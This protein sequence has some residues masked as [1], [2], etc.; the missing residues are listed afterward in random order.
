MFQLFFQ[1]QHPETSAYTITVIP[2]K[3]PKCSERVWEVMPETCMGN[4][5]RV[6]PYLY[7]CYGLWD[8]VSWRLVEENIY[9]KQDVF[10]L[11]KPWLHH[12]CLENVSS[13]ISN[14]RLVSRFQ[15]A[16]MFKATHSNFQWIRLKSRL[17]A[18][19]PAVSNCTYIVSCSCCWWWCC[20]GGINTLVFFILVRGGAPWFYH[21]GFLVRMSHL[22]YLWYLWLIWLVVWNIWIIFPYIGKCHHPNWLTHI[23]QR[24]WNVETTNQ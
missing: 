8:L 1:C 21:F 18:P 24:G 3:T 4:L 10:G 15:D 12:P 5:E 20:L 13:V 9:R 2:K 23:F 19:H 17:S 14:M 16:G 6:G 7:S 22:L 11:L